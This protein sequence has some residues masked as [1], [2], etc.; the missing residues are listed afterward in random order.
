QRPG[1]WPC[2]RLSQE[3]PIRPAARY[4]SARRR[5]RASLL[6]GLSQRRLSQPAQLR[7][8]PREKR[9]SPRL[10]PALPYRRLEELGRSELRERRRPPCRLRQSVRRGW[11]VAALA[12]RWI[13]CWIVR[14]LPDCYLEP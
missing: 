1:C 10:L 4:R 3:P 13:R 7:K 12:R 14:R 2:P 5:R 6:E 8:P 9:N 11:I